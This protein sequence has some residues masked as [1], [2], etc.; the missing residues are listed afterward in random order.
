MRGLGGNDTYVVDNL[1]DVV[2][3]SAAG[4]GGIDT[5]LSS[6]NIDL[7]GGTVEVR[8]P[9]PGRNRARRRSRTSR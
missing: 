1:G 3:E 8:Q 2:D 5:V 9:R 4:S 6:V 7:G